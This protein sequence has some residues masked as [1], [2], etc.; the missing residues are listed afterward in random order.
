MCDNKRRA[1]AIVIAGNRGESQWRNDV[2]I[3]RT[4]ST[5]RGWSRTGNVGLFN[6]KLLLA[7]FRGAFLPP[8]A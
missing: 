3:R 4:E 2:L 6:K 5:R 7:Q 8:F 1:I